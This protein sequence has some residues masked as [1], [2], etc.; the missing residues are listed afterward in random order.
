MDKEPI[1]LWLLQA[2]EGHW[3][4]AVDT[5]GEPVLAYLSGEAAQEGATAHA[6]IHEVECVPVR[7]M[8][9]L[10]GGE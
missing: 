6:G 10:P 2:K 9:F 8:C 1:A 4:P 5:A 3:V 7:T